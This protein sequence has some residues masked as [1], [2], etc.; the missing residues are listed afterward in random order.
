LLEKADFI[1][2]HTPLAKSGPH[3]TY[4]MIAKTQLQKIKPGAVL[5]NTARGSII[6]E[7]DL[8]S[9]THIVRCLDVFEYEPHISR[10][11]LDQLTIATPHI[12]GY[13]QQAK[14]LATKRVFEQAAKFFGWEYDSQLM[15][16]LSTQLS[17][18]ELFQQAPSAFFDMC[19]NHY[20]PIAHTQRFRNAL[21]KCTDIAAAFIQ[22]RKN[23]GFRE[24]WLLDFLHAG[25]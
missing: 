11:L 7:I 18:D 10:E 4:H 19:L 22:E 23:A 8:L 1:T 17:K 24:Q 5:L 2:I 16:L 13:T 20:D 6:N 25:S 21:K 15:P 3:P 14:Y 9:A 12:A